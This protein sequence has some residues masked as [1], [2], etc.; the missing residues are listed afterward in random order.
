LKAQDIRV[1]RDWDKK[2]G[3]VLLRFLAKDPTYAPKVLA[4]EIGHLVDWLPDKY[5]SRGNIL[6]RI[7][8]LKKYLKTFLEAYPGGPAIL[9]KKD[10]A[11]LRRQAVKQAG[12]KATKEDIQKLYEQLR[13][14]EIARR[15]LVSREEI[16]EE[17][18]AL[19][20]WWSPFDEDANPRYTAYRYSPEELYAEAISVLL[21]NPAGLQQQAPKFYNAFFAHLESKKEAKKI[22]E[23]ISN[24]IRSGTNKQRLVTNT[25][26]GMNRAE[27]QLVD[28]L[29]AQKRR[30]VEWIK[31]LWQGFVDQFAVLKSKARKAWRSQ[32][33]SAQANPEWA[34]ENAVYSETE[35]KRYLSHL[36]YN[37]INKLEA[38]NLDWTDFNEYLFANRII[39][40]R[41]DKA[42]PWGWTEADAKA[43]LK[44]I[45][46]TRGPD[47][48]QALEEAR[49][50]FWKM[51]K[52]MVV[53]KAVAANAHDQE[54][55]D[56][57]ADNEYYATFL[58]IEK[59][60]DAKFGKGTGLRIHRQIGTL[61]PIA[62]P[63]TATVM[64]DLS[65]MKAI[66]WNNAKRATVEMLLNLYP[67]EIEA[68]PKHWAGDRQ[69]FDEPRDPNKKLILFL[70]QGKMQGYWVNAWVA[71]G[72][73]KTDNPTLDAVVRILSA[74][75]NPFRK[76]FTS[77]R[78]GFQ[79]F[80]A[81]RDYMRTVA[82]LPGSKAFNF[83]PY[84][85]KA[86]GPAW[87][88]AIGKPDAII[89]AMQKNNMLL[90]WADPAGLENEDLVVERL[91]K[92]YLHHPKLWHQHIRNPL[93]SL[94][95]GL[96]KLGDM[97]EA[98]PKVGAYQYLKKN[99]P[100]MP[101][102]EIAHLVRTQGGSPAFLNRGEAAPILNNLLLFSNAMI[103]GWR[104]DAEAFT[105][106]KAEYAWKMAKYVF[107][108]KAIQY[109][110]ASGA[111]YQLYLLMG[112]DDD[113]DAAKYLKNIKDMYRNVSQYDMLNYIPIPLGLTPQGKTV[114]LRIPLNETQ[115]FI[116]GLFYQSLGMPEQIYGDGIEFPEG[117]I[118]YGAGQLPNLHP[119]IK[120][121][122][123]VMEY[124]SGRNPYDTFRGRN[125]IP[126]TMWKAQTM[127]TR[128]R[129]AQ[130][131][132]NELGGSLIYRFQSE[133]LED[134]TN[135]E[136]GFLAEFVDTAN[137]LPFINDI[138]GRFVKITDAGKAQ[139]LE[140]A[141]AKAGR[142][143][144]RLAEQLRAI[145]KKEVKGEALTYQEA[146][147]AE[148]EK[149]RLKYYQKSM[150][151][152]AGG[153]Y[154]RALFYA[155]S[156]AEKDV[157]QLE[158][159]RDEGKE[160]LLPLITQD[161]VS[162]AN[163]LASLKPDEKEEIP[164]WEENVRKAGA[165]MKERRI[166]QAD[167]LKAYAPELAKMKTPAGR[168]AKKRRLLKAINTLGVESRKM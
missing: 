89:D 3:K 150:K 13:D 124:F 62:G 155:K 159:L 90:T 39:H 23:M 132:S 47:A 30:K 115:R 105:N 52:E 43:R 147:L 86:F 21:N 56:Y 137:R 55:L 151:A 2:A 28:Q 134:I 65:L 162:K 130:W 156:R 64:K 18:K 16:M 131:I 72:F 141:S 126:E 57:M 136:L 146:Q 75:T 102:D 163:I 109:S 76:V 59:A 15:G 6:G 32:Q 22:Y 167:I 160:V 4:H 53:D 161:I 31:A 77:L 67:N 168:A 84:W 139:A 80:N 38:Y 108:P 5:S 35:T 11:R 29:D 133:N 8:S 46:M 71:K 116:G 166:T 69:V 45:E 98:I 123:A 143:E 25:R 78:P 101:E 58:D 24:E 10:R 118:D 93:A 122:Q 63:A 37:V 111:L 81:L 99:F 91:L 106:N 103:Q 149:D 121:G 140:E 34:I 1:I 79:L 107:L 92:S 97:I 9:H 82:N 154:A 20:Q 87:H 128:K 119:A 33:L 40:E 110:L 145:A 68:A 36:Y 73:D 83:F 157:I 27:G 12:D 135:K 26:Q 125:V 117:L 48:L 66:N 19:T 120:V 94:F 54:L 44:E 42:N 50:A 113:D 96:L 138:L 49:Q 14:A 88:N 148:D 100:N 158:I 60:I 104:G 70:H 95:H 7:A 41:S 165:W 164:E 127:E 114:L 17:L 142:E 51:R 153:T 144:A 74:A 129:F 112:G 61:S 85:L 152:Q